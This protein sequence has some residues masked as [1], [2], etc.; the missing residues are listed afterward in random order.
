[1]ATAGRAVEPVRNTLEAFCV[2]R[3]LNV[4]VVRQ[5]RRIGLAEATPANRDHQGVSR[6]MGWSYVRA[7]SDHASKHRRLSDISTCS[8]RLN[9]A[10]RM[11]I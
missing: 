1:M 7:R 8:R 5:E 9:G 6:Y 4:L 3:G 2:I 10:F 11:P